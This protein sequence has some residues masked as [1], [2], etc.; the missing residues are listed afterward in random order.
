MTSVNLKVM[1]VLQVHKAPLV[2]MGSK[3][4]VATPDQWAALDFEGNKE[5]RDF[6]GQKATLG[7]LV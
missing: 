2:K 5:I 1:L 7:T 6:Q 4:T 3:V